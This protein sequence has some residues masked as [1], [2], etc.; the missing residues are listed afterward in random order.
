MFADL[1]YEFAIQWFI[2]DPFVIKIITGFN[3]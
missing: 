3:Q 2:C 1:E